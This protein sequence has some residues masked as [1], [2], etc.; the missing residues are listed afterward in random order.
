MKIL[1]CSAQPYL[2]QVVGGAQAS[3]H[4]LSLEARDLGHSVSAL[5]GLGGE[6]WTALRGR[7]LLRLQKRQAVRDNGLGYP[8]FRAWR[9]EVAAAD[10]ARS[11]KPDV[12]VIPTSRAVPL[13]QALRA[14][15]VPLVVY[16]R[17]VEFD[18]LG[19][20]ISHL[21]G[22]HFI[23]NSHF[24][25]QRYNKAFGIQSTVIPPLFRRE[26]YLSV[27]DGEF[28]TFVNPH[29]LKG[30]DI[31]LA[32]AERLPDIPFNFVSGWALSA[33]DQQRLDGRLK[34]MP[35]VVLRARTRD[36]RE[37]YRQTR[38]L[39]APSRWE[40]AW[41]RIVSEA[42]FSGIPVVAT[43]IGGLPESVGPG[44]ILIDKDAPI[45]NWVQA[46]EQIWRDADLRSRLSE[47]AKTY[48]M[49]LELDRRTQIGLFL[50]VL[51]AAIQDMPTTMSA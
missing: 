8:V 20:A 47:A 42:Q 15:A 37:V 31:A 45:D 19:G 49:R 18:E 51:R 40:E 38:V 23:A 46:V 27:A 3:T 22:A 12:A 10:L 39:I 36:M 26:S 50:S 1:M 25:A 34:G 29:P 4:E 33:E 17:D 13:G 21:K 6:G 48:S 32:L 44:G 24:T 43:R 35:N 9:P 14:E 5:V 11:L 7:V 28:V 41:G 16:L 2:P 30:L